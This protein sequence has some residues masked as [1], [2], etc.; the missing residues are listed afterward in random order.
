MAR[1]FVP[2]RARSRHARRV[3]AQSPGVAAGDGGGG[4]WRLVSAALVSFAVGALCV[5]AAARSQHFFRSHS[6]ALQLIATTPSAPKSWK[7]G[8]LDLAGCA[9]VTMAS[10]DDTG[11]LALALMQSLRDVNTS[12]PHLVLLLMRGGTGSDNCLD[13]EWKAARGRRDVR[14]SAADTIAAE[15]VSEYLLAEFTRLGVEIVIRDP[16]ATTPYT[17][18]IPGGT[19]LFWGMALNKLE[20]FNLTQYRKIIWLD[21]DDY[22]VRSIDHLA[23]APTLTGSL[24]T[25]CCNPYGPA[26]AGGGIWV[27]APSEELFLLILDALSKPRPGTV[28]EGWMLG[29]MQVIRHLFGAAPAEGDDEPLFPAINDERHGYVSGLRYFAEHRNKS[30]P[31]FAAWIDDVLDKRKPRVEGFDPMRAARDGGI[32][33]QALSM[34]YDQC[35][36]SFE[37]SP[38]RDEPDIVYSVHFSCLQSIDKPSSFQSEHDFM[39]AVTTSDDHTRYWFLRWYETYKRATRG[40]GLPPPK[41]TGALTPGA[42][43][44]QRKCAGRPRAT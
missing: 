33:W 16:I 12:V 10:S 9:I 17:E 32:N 11:R 37:C 14:C 5:L 38:E 2:R 20:V 6:A 23:A 39:V 42:R 13:G 29:D 31:E 40:L 44:L 30:E 8:P 15:I 1:D 22:F 35:V 19:G 25:A 27:L 41:W 28:D 43:R 4:A 7:A 3:A 21:A 36:G 34:L 18:G 24:V 26:Y